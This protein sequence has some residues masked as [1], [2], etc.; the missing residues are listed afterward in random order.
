MNPNANGGL[1]LRVANQRVKK[2]IILDFG[3]IDVGETKFFRFVIK[4]L[5]A[6]NKPE[7]RIVCTIGGDR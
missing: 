1:N 4:I 7:S 6:K 2:F 3:L 5:F